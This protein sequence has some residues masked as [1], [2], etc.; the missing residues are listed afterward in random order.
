[1]ATETMER[2]KLDR[3]SVAPFTVEADHHNNC[4]LKIQSIPGCKLRTAVSPAKTYTDPKTGKVRVS[5][6]ISSQLPPIPGMQIA[7]N[8]GD[9]SYQIRDPLYGDEDACE[10]ILDAIQSDENNPFRVMRKVRGVPPVKGTLDEHRMKTLCRELLQIVEA[11]DA[12]VV[13]GSQPA[14]SDIDALPG[15]YLLNPGSVE[16]NSQPLFEKDFDDWYSQL[17]R[18][19][20]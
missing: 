12:K 8:P 19:G 7:V 3:A 16:R 18:S 9:R 10:R 2:Q 20:N 4:D 11:G 17:T 14:L 15:N 1:M 13:K 6:G 5:R